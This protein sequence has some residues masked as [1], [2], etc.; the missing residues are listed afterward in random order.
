MQIK[1]KLPLYYA[2]IGVVVILWLGYVFRSGEGLITSNIKNQFLSNVEN[3]SIEIDK[4]LYERL[5]SL[6]TL[7]T[8]TALQESIMNFSTNKPASSENLRKALEDF[9]LINK[10]FYSAEILDAGGVV[11][12]WNEILEREGVDKAYIVREAIIKDIGTN[13]SGEAFFKKVKNSKDYVIDT[14]QKD[15]EGNIFLSFVVPVLRNTGNEGNIEVVGMIKAKLSIEHISKIFSNISIGSTGKAYIYTTT[16]EI[17]ASFDRRDILTKF[18]WEKWNISTYKDKALIQEENLSWENILAVYKL[19]DGYKKYKGLGWSIKM[20][21]NYSELFSALDGIKSTAYATIVFVIFSVLFLAAAIQWQFINPLSRLLKKVRTFSAGDEN[22]HIDVESKD[23]IGV[24]A[25]AFN[26]MIFKIKE[27]TKILGEYKNIIDSTALVSKVDIEGNFIYVNDIFCNNA[28]CELQEIIGKPHRVIRHPD[29]TD[30]TFKDIEKTMKAKEIWKGIMKNIR[31]DGSEYWLQSV[32]APILDMNNNIVEMIMMETD[33]TELEKTKHELLS[34]YN[35]LQ[36]STD[37]LVVKERISKEFELAGKIQEDFM[38][39]P[40]DMEIEW[41]EVHCG[42]TSATEIGGDLYDII[43]RKNNPDQ[44]L[45]YIGD[46]TGHGLIAGIMMAICNSLTYI[47]AQNAENSIKDIL[48]KLNE[49]LFH[50]LP[51]KVFITFLL[52]EYNARSGAL[53]YAGAGHDNFL[54]YRKESDTVEEIKTGG[55]AIG[56]FQNIANDVKVNDLPLGTGDVV[57]MYTDGIPEARNKDGEF[58]GMERFRE[59]FKSN[60][61]RSVQAMY[62]GILKDLHDFIDGAEI[63]DDITMFLIRKK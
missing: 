15:S 60:A 7:S 54:V 9:L 13:K 57:L 37:A 43:T 38:P 20:T 56:M 22:V 34:S 10:T 23:E 25:G 61:H 33:I 28:G 45:F 44:T 14:P 51:K 32:I 16:G 26:D 8:N 58:Y 48:I 21:Q 5:V 47:L 27:K 55:S 42:I 53:S 3:K 63:L 6:N 46:V 2:A 11:L 31:K 24:L 1:T 17:V 59:S 39:A 50:K 52:L 4:F 19:M 40:E 41:V 62:E 35:K 49:T 18:T 29:I 12:E 36:E 30:E